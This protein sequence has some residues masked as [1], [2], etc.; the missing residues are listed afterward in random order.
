MP[1]STSDRRSRLPKNWNKIR[2]QVKKRAGGRCEAY[3]TPGRTAKTG[4]PHAV[5]CDGYGTDADHILRGDDHS[6][7]NLQWLSGPCHKAKTASE[8]PQRKRPAE[9][10]P[11]AL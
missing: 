2:A 10:H 7:G 3:W 4:Q 5:G 8:G 1:W 11:G 9:R 6:P